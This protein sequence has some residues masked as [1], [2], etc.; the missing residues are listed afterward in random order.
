MTKIKKDPRPLLI[1]LWV[2]QQER[3]PLPAMLVM[4]SLTVGVFANFAHFSLRSFLVAVGIVTLYLIQTRTSDEKKDFEHDNQFH[5]DR[6]VQRGVVSL[7]ELLVINRLSIVSQ[8]A[9]YASFLDM[10]IFLFGLASQ[11][12]AFLTRKE[13]FVREWIRQHFFTYYFLHYIQLVILN[14][15]ILNIIK[16]V[17]V[18]YWQLIT[19]VMLNI[20]IVEVGRK[21]FAVEDD[22]T[23]DTF[24]AQLGHKGSALTLSLTGIAITGGAYY[25]INGHAQNY[26]W[27]ILPVLATGFILNSAYH[28]AIEPNKTNANNVKYAG[29]FML[30]AGMLSVILGA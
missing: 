24:S 20:I 17:G 21:M 25:F 14:L 26:L 23:D 27:I 3:A 8:I 2:F 28:Y 19:F 5:K 1:R 9:L 29:I 12:Y 30:L 15:A 4:A 11:G 6:P 10:R 7:E 18:A 22:T 16:P 13:F